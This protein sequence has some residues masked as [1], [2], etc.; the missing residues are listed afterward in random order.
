MNTHLDQAAKKSARRRCEQRELNARP[1]PCKGSVI[2]TTLCSQKE[3]PKAIPV[4]G[5]EP[6]IFRLEGGRAIQLRHTGKKE[7]QLGDLNPRIR[8]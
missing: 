8:I 7:C 2:T 4:L 1:L 3:C 6:R 5:L